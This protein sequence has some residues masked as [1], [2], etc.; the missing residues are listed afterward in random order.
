MTT[1]RP[2]ALLESLCASFQ[3]AG[4]ALFT[5]QAAATP[6]ALPTAIGAVLPSAFAAR[7]HA[8]R[9]RRAIP[10][11]TQPEDLRQAAALQSP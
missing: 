10:A 9:I 6:I 7:S 11:C 2:A 3:D 1:H 8:S 4:T 5:P